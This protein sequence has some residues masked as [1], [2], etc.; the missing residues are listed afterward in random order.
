[1]YDLPM[2]GHELKTAMEEE[3]KARQAAVEKGKKS[4]T[5]IDIGWELCEQFKSKIG[6]LV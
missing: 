6:G 1:M 4:T 5:V 3:E 2:K